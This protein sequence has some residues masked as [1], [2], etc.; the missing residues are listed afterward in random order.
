MPIFA[1][2]QSAGSFVASAGPAWLNFGRSESQGLQS[3]STFGSFTSSGSTAEVHNAFTAQFLLSYFVT[4]NIAVEGTLGIPPE[5]SV[6]AQGNAAPLGSGGPSLPLGNLHPLATTRAWAPI[7]LAKY[8]FGSPQNK[9]RPY[10]GAGMNY[11]WYSST[12]LNPVFSGALAQFGAPGG[13]VQTSLSASWNPVFTV[14]ASY[15]FS[16][17]WYLTTSVTY[18]PLKTTANINAA[19]QNGNVSGQ[20]SRLD[21]RS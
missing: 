19:N 5:L 3:Q 10:V 8:Y 4:D 16:E 20:P 14:G 6:F 2:A 7:L 17:R 18:L 11:T 21:G 1:F 9:L 13:S 12:H 15:Q